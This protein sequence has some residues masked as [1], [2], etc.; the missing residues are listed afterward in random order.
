MCFQSE[1][2][3]P[4][5]QFMTTPSF[6][7][8]GR[9]PGRI[10]SWEF[11]QEQSPFLST[12]KYAPSMA[13]ARQLPFEL[14]SSIDSDEDRDDDETLPLTK[15]AVNNNIN[16]NSDSSVMQIVRKRPFRV[17]IILLCLLP[18]ILSMIKEQSKMNPPS[19][20]TKTNA[21]HPPS[22]PPPP[23]APS[24]AAPEPDI[25]PPRPEHPDQP[26]QPDQ[27]DQPEKP[28]LQITDLFHKL[29]QPDF[30]TSENSLVEHIKTNVFPRAIQNCRSKRL[31][32]LSPEGT[33]HHIPIQQIPDVGSQTGV[34]SCRG[35]S[36]LFERLGMYV[37]SAY[38]N[39]EKVRNCGMVG[40]WFTEGDW[41]GVL[42]LTFAACLAR[43]SFY[44]LHTDSS[45]LPCLIFFSPAALLH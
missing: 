1:L 3:N 21:N 7:P 8:R 31:N 22:K 42:F 17:L 25:P 40:T 2:Q 24:P 44:A 27:A 30:A 45:K 43:L 4:Q 9:R 18:V 10:R 28:Q 5:M 38:V 6:Y 14:G 37:G 33:F 39:E 15:H 35:K 41:L 11:R 29:Q 20:K 26:D 36:A 12:P 13:T 16:N 32:F 34:G 23:G 19:N